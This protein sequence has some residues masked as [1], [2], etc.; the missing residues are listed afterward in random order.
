MAART[1]ATLRVTKRIAGNLSGGERLG[2]QPAPRA[3][4]CCG[5][6]R[7]V[8][9][10]LGLLGPREGEAAGA[11]REVDQVGVRVELTVLAVRDLPAPRGFRNSDTNLS[12]YG[13]I[14]K[15]DERSL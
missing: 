11:R 15:E 12:K 3:G 5:L 2:P 13:I 6:G 7:V 4:P 9:A 10:P 14:Y 1:C 8:G